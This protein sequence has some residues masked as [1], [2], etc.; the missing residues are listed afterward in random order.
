[1]PSA[2]T[3]LTETERAITK[4]YSD[5]FLTAKIFAQYGMSRLGFT[6]QYIQD[7]L[8]ALN[9][10]M[11]APGTEGEYGA[12]FVNGLADAEKMISSAVNT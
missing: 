5:G 9:T 2:L 4:G 8:A 7:S 11:V 3:N 1:M 12:W 6:G 10:S